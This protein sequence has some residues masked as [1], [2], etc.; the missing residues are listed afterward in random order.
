M[1]WWDRL[2][3]RLAAAL[4][5]QGI[6]PGTPGNGQAHKLYVPSVRKVG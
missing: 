6:A 3:N 2:R 1:T 4:A 5:V